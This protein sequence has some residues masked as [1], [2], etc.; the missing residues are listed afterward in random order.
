MKDYRILAIAAVAVISVVF[1]VPTFVPSLRDVSW[2]P[3]QPINLGLDLQGGM[4]VVLQVDV[5]KAIEDELGH[6]GNDTIKAVF[7]EEN[8]SYEKAYVNDAG[9][10]LVIDFASDTDRS[11]ALDFLKDKW[12]RY[13]VSSYNRDGKIG[14]TLELKD[15]EVQFIR[16]NALR[17]ARETLNNRIDEFNVREPEI[18]TQGRD[19]I[20][21]RLPGVVDPGRAKKLIG[22]TAALE[23]K[24]VN[25]K[26]RFGPSREMLLQDLGGKLTEGYEVYPHKGSRTGQDSFYML[27]KTPDLSGAFL[28]DARVGYD[29]YQNPAVDFQFNEEGARKF[30]DLTSANI[31]KQLVILLDGVVYSAPVIRSRISARG[32]ITGDFPRAEALDLAIVLRAGA[33]PVPVNIEEE[34][35]VGATLGADSIAK[36]RLSFIVG[37]VVVLLFML[38]YYR[39]VGIAANTALILNVMIIMAGLAMFGATLTLPGIAGIVLTIGMAVDANVIINERIREELRNGK[40]PQGA[41]RT[42]YERATWTILDANITTLVAAGVLYNFGTG[43]IR[44]FAVTLSIGLIASVFTAIIVTRVIVERLADRNRETLSI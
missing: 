2:Y 28:T 20:V 40:T 32:Q 36:G 19:Q 34:R 42:G 7:K 6:I 12:P 33:L 43:P 16:D 21:V 29:E 22:R 10:T 11:K 41:V 26:A 27:R 13:S 9:D 4:H 14:A 31:N 5:D 35:T 17:Q 23:F 30:G 3:A 8:L 38:I 24:L 25:E 39:R 1:L 44:G 18:Y 37:G 15:E